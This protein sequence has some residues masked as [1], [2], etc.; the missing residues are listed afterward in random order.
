LFSPTSAG[1]TSPPIP[2][3]INAPSTCKSTFTSPGTRRHWGCPCSS[4]SHR[5]AVR[6]CLHQGASFLAP[7]TFVLT[8]FRLRG[9]LEYLL[10]ICMRCLLQAGLALWATPVSWLFIC[11]PLVTPIIKQSKPV[12][13]LL[14]INTSL[15]SST[16]N[17]MI[18]ETFLPQV[19]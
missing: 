6:Q 14:S 9:V 18:A 19:H 1:A 5:V 16:R 12:G 10:P 15:N 13:I 17:R 11:N 4:C 7:V 3:N 8:T 2:F